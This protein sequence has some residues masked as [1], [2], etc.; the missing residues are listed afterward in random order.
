MLQERIE[1]KWIASF[2][3][4]LKLNGV[5]S[6]TK[7][8]VVAESQSRPVLRQLSEI[9]LYDLGAEYF[10]VDLPTPPQ[11][12]PVPVKSTGASNA[13]AN[14]RPVIEALKNVEVIVDVTVEGLLHAEEW[15]EI[16]GIRL[17]A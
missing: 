11:T 9:A 4:V 16:E 1:G 5:G 12:A 13:I 2:R 6:G 15:T 7:V 17:L 8:A 10:T 3:R 14:M